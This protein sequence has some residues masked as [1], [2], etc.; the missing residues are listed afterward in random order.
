VA[1]VFPY[2]TRQVV[3]L[4]IGTKGK[5][6]DKTTGIR[7]EVTA[8]QGLTESAAASADSSVGKDGDKGED[9]IGNDGDKGEDIGMGSDAILGGSVS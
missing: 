3:T 8:Q 9:I 7:E 4:S 6:I 5:V 2:Y 1:Q